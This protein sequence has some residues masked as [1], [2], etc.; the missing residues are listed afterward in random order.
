MHGFALLKCSA[1]VMSF[2]LSAVLSNGTVSVITILAVDAVHCAAQGKVAVQ[3]HVPH[4]LC[5]I[6]RQSWVQRS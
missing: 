5:T 6:H 3:K 4:A 2:H 1:G